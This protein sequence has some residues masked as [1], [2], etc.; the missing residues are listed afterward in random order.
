MTTTNDDSKRILELLAQG[1]ITVDEADQLLRAVQS[2]SGPPEPGQTGGSGNP[3][4]WIRITIDKRARDGRPPQNVNIRVPFGIVRSGVKLGAMFNRL[5]PVQERL[6]E[7]G[8]DLDSLDFSQL[9]AALGSLGT[10]PVE[11][12]DGKSQVRITCE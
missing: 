8:I 7:K 3:P 2:P 4:R 1:K 10:V 11:I 12:D 6:R 5:E 9:E